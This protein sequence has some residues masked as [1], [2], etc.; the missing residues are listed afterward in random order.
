MIDNGNAVVIHR[1]KA[2]ATAAPV[3][4]DFVQCTSVY[5]SKLASSSRYRRDDTVSERFSHGP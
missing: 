5:A 3:G 1:I 2:V 4:D